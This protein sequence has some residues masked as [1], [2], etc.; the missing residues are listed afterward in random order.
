MTGRLDRL[1]RALIGGLRLAALTRAQ[2]ADLMVEDVLARRGQDLPPRLMS[3]ANGN[4]I[5][6]FHK[7]PVLRDQLGRMDAIDADGMPLVMASKLISPVPLPERV[8][9]TDFFHDAA[10]AAEAH[11]LRFYLLGG[12][13]E[14][15]DA[16]AT[17]IARTYPRLQISGR[18]HGYL[19]NAAIWPL[20]KDIE[21]SG[22]DVLWVGMG[23]P[24]EQAFLVNHASRLRGV[25]WAKTCGGLFD[26]LA[27]NYT[28]APGW[29]Q[30]TGTE[31][32]YRALSEPGRLGKRYAVT[33]L[34]A[35]WHIL[36]GSELSVLPRKRLR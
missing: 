32:L 30:K 16:A 26:F 9:T 29:M 5:A 2:W 21:D 20:L 3:S 22:T 10:K 24:L 28:R 7:D 36:T 8:A 35:A 17:K 13:S 14:V 27:G 4:V 15:N 18:H 25:S 1:P 23:V 19:D 11:T 6:Q 34:S 12:T 33:N 31:W